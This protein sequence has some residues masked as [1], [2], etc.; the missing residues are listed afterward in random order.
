MLRIHMQVGKTGITYTDENYVHDLVEVDFGV[1]VVLRAAKL[2]RGSVW[3]RI[4]RLLGL[5]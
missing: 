1:A 4:K 3:T 5:A 2:A